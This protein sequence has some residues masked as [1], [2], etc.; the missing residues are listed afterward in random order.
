MK[1]EKL[2]KIKAHANAIAKSLYEETDPE[3]VMGLA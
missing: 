3:Q 2:E 1:A